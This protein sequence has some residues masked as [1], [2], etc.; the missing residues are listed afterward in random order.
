MYF[1]EGSMKIFKTV[2]AYFI[3]TLSLLTIQTDIFAQKNTDGHTTLVELFKEWRKF[4]K[5]PLLNGVSNYTI[6]GFNMRQPEFLK[7]RTKL[8][9][10]T[11][12]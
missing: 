1:T 10:K 12:F 2:V 7:L 4:E 9:V 6:A 11:N 5:P 3:L 8:K